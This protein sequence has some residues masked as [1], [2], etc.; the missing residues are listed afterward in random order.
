[1]SHPILVRQQR[2][3]IHLTK[4]QHVVLLCV[5]HP[6]PPSL[7]HVRHVY[8][9]SVVAEMGNSVVKY[10]LPGSLRWDDG[11]NIW[12]RALG[13]SCLKAGIVMTTPCLMF[14]HSWRYKRLSGERFDTEGRDSAWCTVDRRSVLQ[15]VSQGFMLGLSVQIEK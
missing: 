10:A 11:K 6:S 9:W 3:F 7:S 2:L 12:S 8:A 15:F 14:A 13:R 1:M 5:V 4:V